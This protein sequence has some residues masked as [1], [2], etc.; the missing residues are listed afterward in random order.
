MNPIMI[1]FPLVLFDLMEQ[2]QLYFYRNN[3][4]C[5]NVVR[6]VNMGGTGYEKT[7][8]LYWRVLHDAV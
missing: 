8:S 5:Y 7:I 4:G 2:S 6:C 3:S 1:C